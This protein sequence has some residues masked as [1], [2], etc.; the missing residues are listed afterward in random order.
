[1]FRAFVE[2][3]E[4]DNAQEKKPNTKILVG[5]GLALVVVVIVAWLMAG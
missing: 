1:M 4:H 5:I 3:G 2:R